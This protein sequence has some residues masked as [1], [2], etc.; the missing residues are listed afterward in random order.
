MFGRKT[1]LQPRLRFAHGTN[2]SF[3]GQVQV[4]GGSAAPSGD[5]RKNAAPPPNVT[6]EQGAARSAET[7]ID[8]DTRDLSRETRIDFP[9][10]LRKT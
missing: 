9:V 3:G 10:G 2:P 4:Q 1:A 5:A 7:K 8:I 6:I